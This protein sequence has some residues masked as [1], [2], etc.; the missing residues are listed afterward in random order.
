MWPQLIWLALAF[1]TLGM[2]AAN[3]GQ[4][5]SNESFGWTLCGVLLSLS[6]LYW[7]GFF[8]PLLGR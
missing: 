6:L 3:H 2:S 5:R 1:I 8:A 7:G 4:K